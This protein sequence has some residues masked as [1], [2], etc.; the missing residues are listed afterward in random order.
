MLETVMYA[1]AYICR[2]LG[3]SGYYTRPNSQSTW[4]CLLDFLLPMTVRVPMGC[5]RPFGAPFV[6]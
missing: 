2:F 1:Q 3:H 5:V 4:D 6:V